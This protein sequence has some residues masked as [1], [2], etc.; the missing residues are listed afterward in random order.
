MKKVLLA[1]AVTT[2]MSGAAVAQEA[3][4]AQIGNGNNAG[5]I[6]V[7]QPENYPPR[8]GQSN[9][10]IVQDSTNSDGRYVSQGQQ[11]LTVQ[12]GPDNGS[13]TWQQDTGS[14]LFAARH[15]AL[16]W[17][18]GR[19]NS[20]TTV[21][22]ARNADFKSTILQEGN[23]NTAVNWQSTGY[24]EINSIVPNTIAPELRIR[25]NAPSVPGVLVGANANTMNPHVHS[26]SVSN[27]N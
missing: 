14:S 23:G 10:V 16:T 21:Q 17:Q 12:S 22:L 8:G 26:W 20:A 3:F 1:I 18:N 19:R 7:N 11:A 27:S 2:A 4:I 15:T 24:T 6:Q 13:Y 25:N 5:N 9:S